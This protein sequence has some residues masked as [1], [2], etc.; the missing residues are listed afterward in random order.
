[1]IIP[2]QVRQ[3]TV[4]KKLG[5]GTFG[6]V[7]QGRNA[8]GEHVAIKFL[9][10]KRYGTKWKSQT[11]LTKEYS[12]MMEFDNQHILKPKFVDFKGEPAL[13]MPMYSSDIVGYMRT[14]ETGMS[15]KDAIDIGIMVAKAVKC[16][17]DKGYVHRDIKMSNILFCG[18]FE[19]VV[20]CDFGCTDK[21]DDIS[22]YSLVGTDRYIAPEILINAVRSKMCPPIPVGKP[23]DIF[24]L[25]VTL[26]FMVTGEAPTEAHKMPNRTDIE[27]AISDLNCSSQLKDLLR[28]ML[29]IDPKNRLTI[30]QVISKLEEF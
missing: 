6:H 25:G 18:E 29:E 16:I 19:S 26:F 1:M 12:T 21:E 9:H 10:T 24:S 22:P 28:G 2:K 15:E 3:Y 4:L 27:F 8:N 5:N 30:E 14:H 13:V 20:I 7:Y 23:S 11:V 17:H